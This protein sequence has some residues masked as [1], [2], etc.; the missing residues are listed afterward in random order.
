MMRLRT[1][2]AAILPAA[3][4][5]V[6]G[7]P[8]AGAGAPPCGVRWGSLAKSEP[9]MTGAPVTAVRV[10]P[11]HCFDRLVVDL[12]GLP[13]P[14]YHVRYTDGLVNADTGERVAV[15]GGAT[16]MVTVR[17]PVYDAEGRPTMAWR[18]ATHLYG[19]EQ[20]TAFRTLRDVVTAGTY[21]GQSDLAVGVRARLP[22]RVFTLA[23]PG[24]GSR[25]VVDV[26]HRW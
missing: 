22:F 2:A 8:V 15:A 20:L 5:M 10:G 14:G 3:A 6:V 18:W 12:G 11:H 9:A 13:A 16:L 17:A 21:E 25:L 24:S 1:L 23:G 26:A 4:L 7:A 19:P